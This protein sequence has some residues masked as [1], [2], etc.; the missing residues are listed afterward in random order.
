MHL[1]NASND[2]VGILEATAGRMSLSAV[3]EL[4][5]VQCK[6]N[7]LLR[8]GDFTFRFMPSGAPPS[9]AVERDLEAATFIN[10]EQRASIIVVPAPT[11]T[12][13][14]TPSVAFAGAPP[15]PVSS[16]HNIS[17]NPV[18][19]ANP[20]NINT[21]NPVFNVV[22]PQAPTVAHVQ[23]PMAAAH[24]V[25]MT[26]PAVKGRLAGP[27]LASK[28][29]K[30]N[31]AQRLAEFEQRYSNASSILNTKTWEASK[32]NQA[33]SVVVIM[34]EIDSNTRDSFWHSPVLARSSADRRS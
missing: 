28:N 11:A 33:V 5:A 27:F 20:N 16:S 19:N 3:R 22:M 24:N 32:D 31:A 13:A 18:F 17:V 8:D 7:V 1:V 34:V 9:Y 14:P 4:I 10:I 25:Q 2:R 12:R 30:E 21:F 15:P 23:Q 6:T 26:H 29:P